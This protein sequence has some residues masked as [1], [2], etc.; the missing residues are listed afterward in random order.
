M[1]LVNEEAVEDVE[2]AE[3]LRKQ[4]LVGDDDDGDGAR[5]ALRRF[6]LEPN[7]RVPRHTNSVEHVQY[8]LEG[9]YTVE[10]EGEERVAREGD[11]MHVPAGAVHSYTG[12][13]ERGVFLC[14][15]PNEDDEMEMVE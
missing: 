7:A 1:K 6:V 5:N 11:A 2:Q 13:D 3:G 8:V 15:V 14:V 10:V 4:V 9:G 12:G